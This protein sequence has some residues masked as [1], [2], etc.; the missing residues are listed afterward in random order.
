MTH[1]TLNSTD[2][3]VCGGGQQ[4]MQQTADDTAGGSRVTDT[5]MLLVNAHMLL[6]NLDNVPELRQRPET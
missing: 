2:D 4:T 5:S 6:Q 1:S 3:A